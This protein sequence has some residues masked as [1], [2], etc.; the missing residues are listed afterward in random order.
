MLKQGLDGIME[1]AMAGLSTQCSNMETSRRSRC[2]GEAISRLGHEKL[3]GAMCTVCTAAVRRDGMRPRKEGSRKKGEPGP[4][5]NIL[6]D[7]F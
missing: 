5:I 7:A 2:R 1:G 4:A 3:Q 6:N